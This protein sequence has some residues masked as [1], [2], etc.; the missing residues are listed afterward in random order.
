[1]CN[2]HLLIHEEYLP[3][4]TI[5]MTDSAVKSNIEPISV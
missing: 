3:G 4:G 2:L 5:D 1:M